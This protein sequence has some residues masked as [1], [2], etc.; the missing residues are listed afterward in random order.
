MRPCA[1]TATTRIMPKFWKDEQKK[2][3][4]KEAFELLEKIGGIDI[5]QF[6]YNGATWLQFKVFVNINTGRRIF[7]P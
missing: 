4:E 5:N 1:K 6:K 3:E 7:V 2:K